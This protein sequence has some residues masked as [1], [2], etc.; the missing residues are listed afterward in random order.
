MVVAWWRLWFHCLN[1]TQRTQHW[2]NIN[3][4]ISGGELISW[5]S[6]LCG[7]MLKYIP[8]KLQRIREK[9]PFISMEK[10]LWI[11]FSANIYDIIYF[12]PAAIDYSWILF[13]DFFMVIAVAKIAT[14]TMFYGLKSLKTTTMGLVD[15]RHL[16]DDRHAA[17]EA[18][19]FDWIHLN[20]KCSMAHLVVGP[21]SKKLCAKENSLDRCRFRINIPKPYKS[22]AFIIG[23][24]SK[25]H[26]RLV[27]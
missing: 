21:I 27:R 25:T 9:N 24:N 3:K 22:F 6:G 14:N 26:F 12:A 2:V 10:I 18:A 13:F 1:R 5:N 4:R 16:L 17:A 23:M 7:W 8:R 20:C 15:T 19:Q 11:I